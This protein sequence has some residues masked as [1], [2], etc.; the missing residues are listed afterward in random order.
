MDNELLN[1]IISRFNSI[2][3][4][5]LQINDNQKLLSEIRKRVQ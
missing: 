3:S 2:D 5:L 4:S 1:L